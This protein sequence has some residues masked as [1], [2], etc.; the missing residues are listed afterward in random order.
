MRRLAALICLLPASHAARLTCGQCIALQ[1][2]V[3]RSINRNITALEQKNTAGVTSS[4][5][6]EIGQIIWHLCG[7]DA[8]KNARP[9]DQLIAACEEHQRPHTDLMTEYWKEKSTDEYHDAALALRMK[10]AVCPNPEIDACS[11]DELP[12][13]YA[14]LD[15]KSECS[16]CQAVTADVF[17]IIHTSRERPKKKHGDNFFRIVGL[18]AAVCDDLPMRHPIQPTQRDDVLEACQD[19]W[20]DNEDSFVKM[21]FNRSPE[22][23]LSLCSEALDVC[24]EDM[25]PSQL[26]AFDPSNSAKD[27]L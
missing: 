22:F 1:E 26:Y 19:F 3:Y 6:I 12:D 14:P 24:E 18:I 21:V 15:P 8:W 20:D 27:E 25:S 10:R 17:G 7:S 4:A 9:N 13:D 5:T 2:G 16:I 23:A 11:L